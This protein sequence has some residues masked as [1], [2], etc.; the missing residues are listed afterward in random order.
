[1]CN[2]SNG[3]DGLMLSLVQDSLLPLLITISKYILLYITH[4]ATDA[5]L[6]WFNPAQKKFIEILQSQAGFVR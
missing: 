6:L 3:L 5:T 2:N 4:P 1:M